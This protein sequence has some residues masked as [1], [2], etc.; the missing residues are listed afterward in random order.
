[1]LEDILKKQ[2]DSIASLRA[3]LQASKETN[4]EEQSAYRRRSRMERKRSDL[5]AS[6]CSAVLML[7]LDC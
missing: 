3:R 6:K 5:F 7:M 2:T 1:M 4:D